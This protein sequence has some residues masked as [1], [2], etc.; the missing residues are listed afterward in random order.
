MAKHNAK[1]T[2][3]IYFREDRQKWCAQVVTGINTKTGGYI[4]KTVYGNTQAEVV[5]KKK[6]IE[7]KSAIGMYKTSTSYT[8]DAWLTQWLD[9]IKINVEPNTYALYELIVRVPYQAVFR[10]YQA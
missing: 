7:S 3:T 9:M 2:G 6:D 4:R 10:K 5:Q 8:L 1:G